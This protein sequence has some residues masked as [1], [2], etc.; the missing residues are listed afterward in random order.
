VAAA[1]RLGSSS[2][3]R[4]STRRVTLPSRLRGAAEQPTRPPRLRVAAAPSRFCPVCTSRPLLRSLLQRLRLLHLHK[5]RSSLRCR[6]F[7]CSSRRSFKCSSRHSYRLC[8][9][10]RRLRRSPIFNSSSSP[11]P[12]LKSTSH[13][14]PV[15]RSRCST[16]WWT[17]RACRPAVLHARSIASAP[18]AAALTMVRPPPALRDQFGEDD[19]FLPGEY[20]ARRDSVSSDLSHDSANPGHRSLLR[21]ELAQL[22]K[23]LLQEALAAQQ[24][25]KARGLTPAASYIAEHAAR[26]PHNA[27]RSAHRLGAGEKGSGVYFARK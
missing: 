3:R 8:R 11:H 2:T 24:H 1:T 26:L 27:P 22:D 5:L 16:P 25:G 15:P 4:S 20:R 9:H 13:T 7:K 6:P 14:V 17:L 21:A 12:R 23:E 19:K 10:R 18:R